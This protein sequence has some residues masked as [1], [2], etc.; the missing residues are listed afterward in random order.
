MIR[1]GVINVAEEVD[2]LVLTGLMLVIIRYELKIIKNAVY[3]NELVSRLGKNV[4]EGICRSLIV[5]CEVTTLAVIA[6]DLVVK[7]RFSV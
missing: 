2:D 5:A 1:I 3:G 7:H 6:A 4:R